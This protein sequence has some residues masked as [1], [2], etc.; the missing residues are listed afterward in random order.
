MKPEPFVIERTFN[1]PIERVWKAITDREQMKQC[2]LILKTLNLK[3]VLSLNFT[4]R[5]KAENMCTYVK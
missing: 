2:I 5:M 3:W 1:A 4:A